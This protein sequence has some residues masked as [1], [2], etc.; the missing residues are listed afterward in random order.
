MKKFMLAV[1]AMAGAAG[2]VQAAGLEGDQV[3]VALTITGFPAFLCANCTSSFT[4]GAGPEGAI[5][6]GTQ[7]VDFSA[8]AFTITSN[9]SFSQFGFNPAP[10]DRPVTLRLTS[11][12]A[13]APITNVTFT[14]TLTG[15]VTRTFG[16]DFAEFVFFDQPVA[17]GQTYLSAQFITAVPETGT[18]ALMLAGLGAI[19]VSAR[20]NKARRAAVLSA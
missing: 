18:M 10:A 15:P 1:L 6:N 11:L 12:N 3:T 19:G 9:G 8:F 4:V 16:A 5:Y 7:V 13:G 14:T 2:S 17:A 20:R